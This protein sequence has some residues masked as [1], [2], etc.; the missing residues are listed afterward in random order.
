MISTSTLILLAH[1]SRAEQTLEEMA[2]LATKLQRSQKGLRVIPAFLSLIKPDLTQALALAAAKGATVV[3]VLPLFLFTG[4]HMLE[5]IPAQIKA[6]RALYPNMKLVL[7]KAI[8]HH[9][10]FADFLLKA[11]GFF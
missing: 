1:G 3:Q 6:N 5:D 4:K 8:G 10:S 2:K 11:S 9:T 7:H